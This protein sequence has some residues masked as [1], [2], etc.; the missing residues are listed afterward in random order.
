MKTRLD[1]EAV[2]PCSQPRVRDQVRA[3]WTFP[4]IVTTTETATF[5]LQ[6]KN[7]RNPAKPLKAQNVTVV[8]VC[9][10]VPGVMEL[11]VV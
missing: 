9:T 5:Q 3:M 6:K 1:S 4:Q 11:A 7:S 2:E 10:V 8:T